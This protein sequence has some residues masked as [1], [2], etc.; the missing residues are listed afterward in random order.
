VSESLRPV[1]ENRWFHK[2]PEYALGIIQYLYTESAPYPRTSVGNNLSDWTRV[3]EEI[4]WPIIK[5]LA[6][7]GDKNSYWI[8][9]RACRNLV[10]KK[11]LQVMEIL[12][13]EEYKYKSR[14]YKKGDYLEG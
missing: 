14:V 6:E 3:N 12:G 7:S 10:K 11:P 1:V 9:T 4:A 2:N 8:A 13:V 5:S